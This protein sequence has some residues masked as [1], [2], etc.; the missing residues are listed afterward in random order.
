MR[1]L[2]QLMLP[3]RHGGSGLHTV[4]ATTVNAFDLGGRDEGPEM[5]A[6]CGTPRTRRLRRHG[7]HM[8]DIVSAECRWDESA[9][10]LPSEFMRDVLGRTVQGQVWR[11]VSDC[12]GAAILAAIDAD[13]PQGR[14]DHARMCSVTGGVDSAWLEAT[15]RS[16]A[17]DCHA[18]ICL[19]K[20]APFGH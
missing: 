6:I 4:D 9:R 14:G 16:T 13:T 5:Q 19:W 2:E 12:A 17:P 11:I 7:K 10:E 3:M 1:A 8:W 20:S 15:R 18:R